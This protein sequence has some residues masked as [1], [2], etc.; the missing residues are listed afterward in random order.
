MLSLRA[1]G[2]FAFATLSLAGTGCQ[3]F[4][5]EEGSASAAPH[6]DRGGIGLSTVTQGVVSP[7]QVVNTRRSLG[8][9]DQAITSQFTLL[10]VMD[11]LAAQ[12]GNPAFTGTQL[13]RQLWETQ[14]AVAGPADLQ[15]SAH[16][17]DNGTS[18][19]G[20][21]NICRP[22]EGAQANAANPTNI[23]SYSAIGLFN[24]FDLAPGDGSNCGE[25]RVVFGKTS[26]G[27]GRSF[28]IFEA[29][30]PNPRLELGIEGCR[31]VQ[32]F[33]RDLSNNPSVPARATALRNFYFNGLPGYAPVLHLANYGFN[34]AG[35]GQIR[36]NMFMGGVWDLKE[37]KLERQ[38][39]GGACKL[40]AIPATVKTNP[41]GD[42]FNPASPNAL[43]GDFQ[44]HF[45]TQVGT[46]AL[47]DVNR[48]NYQ[49]PDQFNN[50]HSDAQSF[51]VEDDYVANFAGPSAFRTLIQNQLTALGSA[52]TPDNIVARAQA[53]S[54]GGCHQRNSGGGI[55]GGITFPNSAGFVHSSEFLQASPDGGNRFILSSALD[56]VFLPFRKSIVEEY[57]SAVHPVTTIT[58]FD[59]VASAADGVNVYW[60]E[61]RPSGSIVKASLNSGGEQAIAFNRANPT[62]V[63]TDGVSVYWAEASGSIF[64]VSVNGG[65]VTT[66]TTGVP[67]LAGLATDGTSVFWST[68]GSTIARMPIGGGAITN[69]ITGRAGITSRL[70]VDATSLYWQEGN[71]ILKA[72]KAGGA[73]TTLITRA[74]ITGLASD[75]TNV[76]LAENLN[77]G[78]IL[79]LPVG[80]GVVTNLFSGS[81][82]LTSVAV[83]ATN[84]VWTSNTSP[85]P[86]MT[87]VK[88]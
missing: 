18:L 64:K 19:N 53:L 7:S 75:G 80:G 28:I 78:N 70:A 17:S 11:Q 81:F 87:K 79:R 8:V 44:T 20:F 68:N 83:G 63:A 1:I 82:N 62:A 59:M 65:A 85:G 33:W 25:Y 21:N 49:V 77:P 76:Y 34:F 67:A 12:N 46:L 5:V 39:P 9:T 29:I 26:G 73:V 60:A 43:A 13:F 66:L 47:N 2:A 58:R 86:V 32:A 72:A 31:Q 15:P 23:N 57:L 84:F 51:G 50:P 55:G 42:L 40:K 74:S 27:G 24:R 3:S 71:N 22:T 48:F 61:N 16:C 30:L 35:A 36:V 54:C 56:N 4:G 52:L 10:A 41:F 69:V 45:L 6:S 88:N 14:N 37:F 38:C